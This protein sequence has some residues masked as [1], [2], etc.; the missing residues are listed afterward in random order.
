MA[1]TGGAASAREG[2][3]TGRGM[4]VRH[5]GEERWGRP[6]PDG[7]F[8][9]EDLSATPSLLANGRPVR[10]VRLGARGNDV[11]LLLGPVEAVH[12]EPSAG[13]LF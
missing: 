12:A 2:E 5:R 6:R 9:A 7:D 10:S 11:V 8:E 4:E 13:V 3:A 1:S